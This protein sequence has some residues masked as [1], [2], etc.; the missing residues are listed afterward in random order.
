MND[1][2]KKVVCTVLLIASAYGFAACSKEEQQPT[3]ESYIYHPA[4]D[5]SEG[6]TQNSSAPAGKINADASWKNN[7][8][9]NYTYFNN[10]QGEGKINVCEKRSENFFSAEDTD[11][12]DMLF[13]KM[14]GSD[15]DSYVIVPDE[16]EQVH[17]VIA[18]KSLS[19]LSSTFM[20][21]SEVDEGLPSLSNVMY[22]YDE[23]VAGRDCAKYVQRAYSGGE[24]TKTVYVWVDAQYGF[25]AK[26]EVYDGETKLTASWETTSFAAGNVKD[27]DVEIDLSAYTFVEE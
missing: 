2:V 18:G 25:A 23:Q 14:N 13:Y 11:S 27:G 5:V 1:T 17:S 21:L 16:K 26:G 10:S 22:M 15:I 12:G 4:G 7:F 6:D 3:T 9:V 19:D 20:K 8:T 24:L